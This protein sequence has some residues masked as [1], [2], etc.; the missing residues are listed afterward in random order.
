MVFHEASNPLHAKRTSI[1][2]EGERRNGC[3]YSFSVEYPKH[4][5]HTM[6]FVENYLF[7]LSSRKKKKLSVPVLKT[8]NQ[9]S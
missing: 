3:E 2:M 6:N 8:Y 9:L 7:K 1:N 5:T 4:I